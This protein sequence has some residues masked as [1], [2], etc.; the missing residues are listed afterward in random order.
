VVLTVF[1]VVL[2]RYL[3]RLAIPI[4]TIPGVLTV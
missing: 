2:F 1:C 3:L 4:L